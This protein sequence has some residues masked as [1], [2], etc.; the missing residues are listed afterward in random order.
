[1]RDG[2]I[3]SGGMKANLLFI[4][5]FECASFFVFVFMLLFFCFIPLPRDL[6]V[7]GLVEKDIKN[8]TCVLLSALGSK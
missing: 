6:L 3:G 4:E 8:H 1:M 2:N 5:I 7:D